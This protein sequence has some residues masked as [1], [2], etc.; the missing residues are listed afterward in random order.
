[1]TA[2][3]FVHKTFSLTVKFIWSQLC[4]KGYGA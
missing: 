2:P 4:K 1:M 3:W